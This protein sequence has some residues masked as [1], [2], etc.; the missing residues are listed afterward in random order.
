MGSKTKIERWLL[1]PD[2]HHPYVDRAAYALMLKAA[3]TIGLDNIVLLGDFA[4]MQAVSSHSKRPDQRDLQR[5]ADA[6]NDALDEL[7]SRFKGQKIYVSGNHEDR[8]QRYLQ[9]KAPE[10]FNSMRVEKLFR[11]KERGWKFVPYKQHTKVGKLYITHDAGKA[12]ATAHV[13]ALNAFQSNAVIGHTHRLAYVVQGSAKGK[14][15]VGA[16]LGWLGDF[17]AVDYMHR[18]RARREWAHGFGVA[19]V[20]PDGCVHLVP[21]P[22]V[23]GKV[24]IEGRLVK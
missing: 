21:I 16:M 13:D 2:C 17:D 14:A 1:V 4:D 5:E 6:V 9:D 19:Y 8:L 12:G 23:N 24:V 10:L 3:K 22:I 20:E 11:L 15:H 18:I 7:D